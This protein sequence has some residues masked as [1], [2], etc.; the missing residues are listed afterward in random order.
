VSWQDDDNQPLPPWQQPPPVWQTSQPQWPPMEAPQS[1]SGLAIAALVCS[2]AGFIVCQIVSIVGIVLG[3]L[4]LNEISGSMG[5]KTG[6]GMA[7]AGIV[8]GVCGVA[9]LG[10]FFAI[11]FGSAW[12]D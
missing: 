8:I 10:V 12:L 7:I 1:T 11:G 9:L 5:R 4:A 6:R 3:I 2:L